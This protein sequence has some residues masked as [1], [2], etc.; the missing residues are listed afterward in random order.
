MVSTR[1]R[2]SSS[3]SIPAIPIPIPLK[4]IRRVCDDGEGPQLQRVVGRS[5]RIITRTI[6]VTSFDEDERTIVP[7]PPL[8]KKKEKI[9]I[10]LVSIGQHDAA[11]AG[12]SLSSSSSSS[13]LSVLR[14][15]LAWR[16]N[17]EYDLLVHT[18]AGHKLSYHNV[19][20]H[21]PNTTARRVGSTS[22]RLYFGHHCRCRCQRKHEHEHSS[23]I[24]TTILLLLTPRIVFSVLLRKTLRHD[25]ASIHIYR[26]L[27]SHTDGILPYHRGPMFSVAG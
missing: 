22:K 25:V 21:P 2:L 18:P 7:S 17:E 15:N 27:S 12:L 11:A 24:T 9:L 6:T 16:G 13:S 23:T 3:S 8:R 14:I 4:I 10:G 5:F 1:L 26:F 20:D 19:W